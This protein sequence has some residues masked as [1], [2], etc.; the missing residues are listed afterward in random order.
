MKNEK[1]SVLVWAV[2][3]IMIFSVFTAAALAV[4]YSMHNRSVRKN[5]ERQLYFTA[6]SAA[7]LVSNEMVS[8]NGSSLINEV[9]KNK[10][11]IVTANNIFP[12]DKNM[13][14]CTVN[15]KC[16]SAGNQIIVTATAQNDDLKQIVS[17]ILNKNTSTNK[18]AIQAYDNKDIND[19][20]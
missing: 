4:S 5:T 15:V 9:V 19:S 7:V 20:R 11:N 8:P 16:N 10:T 13:G 2:V 14:N 12:A 3:I 18:W 17:A 6:R 1:G